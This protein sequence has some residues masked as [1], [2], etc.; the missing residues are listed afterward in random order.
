VGAHI[1]KRGEFQSDKY[2]GCPPGKVPLSVKD[3]TAQDLLWEYAQ[4][5]R[6]VDAE[7]SVDLETSLMR[8]GFPA[9]TGPCMRMKSGGRCGAPGVAYEVPAVQMGIRCSACMAS[10]HFRA[11]AVPSSTSGAAAAPGTRDGASDAPGDS[12]IPFWLVALTLAAGISVRVAESV[13]VSWSRIVSLGR[14]P[15]ASPSRAPGTC[16][17][18][19]S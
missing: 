18:G 11:K 2:P 3:P 17:T 12:T 15:A 5:R 10:P 16:G 7:F 8:A 14:R 1:N 19:R 9:Q 6:A 4:R 13:G